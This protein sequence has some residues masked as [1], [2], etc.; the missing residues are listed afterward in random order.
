MVVLFLICFLLYALSSSRN[1]YPYVCS[2]SSFFLVFFYCS[3]D[4]VCF[5]SLYFSVFSILICFT[6][7]GDALLWHRNPF[8]SSPTMHLLRRLLSFSIYSPSLF[9]SCFLFWH[10]RSSIRTI[11]TVFNTELIKRFHRVGTVFLGI[12]IVYIDKIYN[13]F[14]VLP[15]FELVIQL[16][17]L[18][19]YILKHF[20]VT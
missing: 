11:F 19:P 8:H 4:A 17:N 9:S 2:V 15:F 1:I 3:H 20:F 18:Y 7:K 16:L 14:Y 5:C 12:Y 10:G 6:V 13:L